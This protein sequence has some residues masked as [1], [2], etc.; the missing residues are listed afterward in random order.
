[1][2]RLALLISLVALPC[3]VATEASAAWWNVE[4][5][6]HRTW[7]ISLSGGAF[8][9]DI[10]GKVQV[11]TVL[12]GGMVGVDTLDLDHDTSGWGEID[13]QLFRKHHLRFVYLPIEFDGDTV[14]DVPISFGGTT[15]DVAD[16]V[17]SY[18]RLDTYELSYRY[19]IYLGK[20]ATLSPLVQLSLVDGRVEVNDETLGVDSDESQLVPVPALGLHAEVYPLARVGVFGEGKAFTIGNEGTMWDVQ[21]GL[22]LHLIRHLHLTASY[23]VVDY[24]VD[25]LDVEVDTRI[26]GPYV[27]ATLRF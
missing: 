21:G 19:D 22:N 14:L 8:R 17:K 2:G 24:N 5:E 11:E 1:M 9:Q 3:L 12:G 18:A 7:K 26:Q 23:R 6:D 25:Y 15:F 27:G 20:W 4:H 10:D 13:L 16:R